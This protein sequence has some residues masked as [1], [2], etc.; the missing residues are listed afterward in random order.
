M[1]KPRTPLWLL[2]IAL[3]WAGLS[4]TAAAQSPSGEGP[5][6]EQREAREQADSEDREARSLFQAGQDAFSD[7][8][9]EEALAS[10]REAYALTEHPELLYNIATS[11][12]RLGRLEDAAA[13]YRAFLSAMPRAANRNYVE[14]RIQVIQA[15]LDARAAEEAAREADPP[16]DP[17]PPAREEPS[18]AGPAILLGVGG[19]ALVAG[20]VT[21]ILANEQYGSLE[22]QCPGGACS[23]E[24]AGDIDTLTALTVSTD[25]LFGVALVAAAAGVLWWVLDDGGEV[26]ASAACGPTG[27][28]GAVR[29]VF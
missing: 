2:T 13:G 5:P 4:A 3:A 15:Q 17:T 29:G 25:V 26:E 27:C 14:R 10:W 18:R 7:G 19:A 6:D 9:F 28:V 12:D 24:Q 8:R 11:L 1:T 21:A 22:A 16:A 23:A 20:V